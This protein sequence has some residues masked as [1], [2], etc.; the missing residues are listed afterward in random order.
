MRDEGI[1]PSHGKSHLVRRLFEGKTMFGDVS[2]SLFQIPL[3]IRFRR[4]PEFVRLA[5]C[6]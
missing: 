1:S 2:P 5:A 3:E 4:S 6:R